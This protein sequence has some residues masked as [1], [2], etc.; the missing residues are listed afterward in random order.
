MQKKKKH[1]NVRNNAAK[2]LSRRIQKKKKE[3]HAKVSFLGHSAFV[4]IGFTWYAFCFAQEAQARDTDIT[5]SRDYG[6]VLR[7]AGTRLVEMISLQ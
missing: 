1:E 3:N 5:Q 4:A 7:S 2:C 6:G